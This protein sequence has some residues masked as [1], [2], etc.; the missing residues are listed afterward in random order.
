MSTKNDLPS[1]K[2]ESP[3]GWLLRWIVWWMLAIAVVMAVGSILVIVSSLPWL[4]GP[5]PKTFL[6]LFGL[7]YAIG[8]LTTAALLKIGVGFE[9]NYHRSVEGQLLHQAWI[10]RQGGT[11]NTEADR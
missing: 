8:I 9:A 3:H 5:G 11:I 7:C 2:A 4:Y 6:G 1:K 10:R